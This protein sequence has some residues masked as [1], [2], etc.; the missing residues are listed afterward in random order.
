MPLARF[1]KGL[2]EAYLKGPRDTTSR[3]P[4]SLRSVIG[5]LPTLVFRSPEARLV[6][7]LDR[8]YT[9]TDGD[10]ADRDNHFMMSSREIMRT[11]CLSININ[12]LS[13]N[14]AAM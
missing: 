11:M 4:K 6:L 2:V 3:G 7:L 10:D 12:E 8:R 5:K 9:K 14:S 1:S 13:L